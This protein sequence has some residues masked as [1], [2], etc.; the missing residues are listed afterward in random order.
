M[1]LA[2]YMNDMPFEPPKRKPHIAIVFGYYIVR[3]NPNYVAQGLISKAIAFCLIRNTRFGIV[4]PVDA[5]S[6]LYWDDEK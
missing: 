1:A 3:A 5:L 6:K 2:R 4:G